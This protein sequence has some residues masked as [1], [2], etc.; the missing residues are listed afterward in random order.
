MYKSH[1]STKKSH[2]K[3]FINFGHLLELFQ[4]VFTS[5]ILI[6]VAI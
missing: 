6:Q 3:K 5:N 1:K 4:K 2:E